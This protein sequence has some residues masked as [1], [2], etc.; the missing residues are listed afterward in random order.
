MTIVQSGSD[1]VSA[2]ATGQVA[3]AM[4]HGTGE[5]E[6][7]GPDEAVAVTMREKESGRL[8]D[9]SAGGTFDPSKPFL[10]K[11]RAKTPASQGERDGSD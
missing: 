5:A 1:E 11:C 7:G 3:A 8:H 9:S 6:N 2:L 10:W 4:H